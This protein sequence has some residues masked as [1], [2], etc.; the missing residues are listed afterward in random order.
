LGRF[1]APPRGLSLP[2]LNAGRPAFFDLSGR[3]KLRLTGADVFRFLNG[4]VTNDIR[5]ATR[6]AAI[7]ASILNAKGKLSAHVFLSRDEESV[8]LLDAD[9]DL[10]EELS[11]RLDRY[12]IADDVQIE[13]VTEQFSLL[14]FLGESAPG[15]SGGT[16]AVASDRFGTPGWD[17]WCGPAPLA[18]LRREFDDRFDFCDEEC[19]E[20][21]R[22]ER[23]I[24]RWGR[25]LTNEI[26]PVEANLETS[27]IDYGKGCYI[28]QEVI[29]RMKMSGQTNKRLCGLVSL[30]G[31]PLEGGTP[32]V[33][34]TDASR[35]AGWITS[36]TKSDRLGKQIGL[37]YA[38][39][40]FN[41]PGTQLVA[42]TVPVEV[43]ALPF[44]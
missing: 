26:I 42:G 13:D 37:G 29:S 39:R 7:Q 30:N 17:Y 24:P 15:A 5:K 23:G 10:R 35:E 18:E 2:P 22:I 27:S 8:F 40:G 1:L 11:G 41:N 3:A 34:A 33:S 38:K 12:I 43:T 14:H 20:V 28:G 31:A 4:Q 19:T 36:A 32:L 9:P 16:R 6:T 25:E 44:H 21:F